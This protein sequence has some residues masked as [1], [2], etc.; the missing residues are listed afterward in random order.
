LLQLTKIHK[1]FFSS[2]AVRLMYDPQLPPLPPQAKKNDIA[3]RFPLPFRL[4]T[5]YRNFSKQIQKALGLVLP[6][7]RRVF[8]AQD[9]ARKQ[10]KVY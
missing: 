5:T 8:S 1:V 6:L 2:Q 7:A 9:G 3:R 4:Q 10:L